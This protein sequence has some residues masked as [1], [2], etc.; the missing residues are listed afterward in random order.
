MDLGHFITD[1]HRLSKRQLRVRSAK[2]SALA[3]LAFA[4]V[5]WLDVSVGHWWL[6]TFFGF[7]FGGLAL[8][9]AALGLSQFLLSRKADDGAP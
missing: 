3:A 9:Y 7:V 8:L 5:C 2:L 1:L 6:H 4:F